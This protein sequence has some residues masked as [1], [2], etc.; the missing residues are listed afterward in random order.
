MFAQSTTL[1]RGIDS[2]FEMRSLHSFILTMSISSTNGTRRHSSFRWQITNFLDTAPENSSRS[3]LMAAGTLIP[4]RSSTRS[5]AR[6]LLHGISLD[7]HPIRCLARF[8]H[9]WKN[10]V[11]RRSHFTVRFLWPMH[12][13]DHDLFLVVVSNSRIL[14]LFGYVDK[15]TVEEV[16]YITFL[17]MARAGLKALEV[18]LVFSPWPRLA[19][20]Y[21]KF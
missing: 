20:R 2:D 3:R 19:H 21:L 5:L 4:R 17:L 13:I 11:L 7:K 6:K 15:E 14:E 10:A 12:R 9:P 18:P 16:Q 1:D 8:R